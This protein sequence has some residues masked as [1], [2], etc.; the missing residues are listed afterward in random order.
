MLAAL[1]L[2][3]H[4]HAARTEQTQTT[5]TD[6]VVPVPVTGTSSR[7]EQLQQRE[8]DDST[9]EPATVELPDRT[10]AVARR[11]RRARKGPKTGVPDHEVIAA[12]REREQ[13]G[14]SLS[15]RGVMAEFRM[16]TPRATRLMA[17][18]NNGTQ[19]DIAG[20]HEGNS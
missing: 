18:A 15:R 20:I 2:T 8:A 1:L 13:N 14:D 16:G 5:G 10:P 6:T 12:L 9:A 4:Y 11:P 17:A 19:F 3:M 7:D